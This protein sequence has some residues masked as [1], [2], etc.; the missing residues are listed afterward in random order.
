MTALAAKDLKPPSSAGP[1]L[2][3]AED[4]PNSRW[5]LCA[6]VKRMGFDCRAVGN[7][8]EVLDL[9]PQFRPRVILMDLMMPVLDGLEATRRLKSDEA[10]RSIPI[11]VL[12]GN[13]TPGNEAAAREAGCDA[14]VPKPIVWADLQARL[15]AFLDERQGH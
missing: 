11:V 4:D 2:L 14:F 9:V 5:V 7:G 3:I 8:R 12:T 13:V 10:T 6:L 15:L 1:R